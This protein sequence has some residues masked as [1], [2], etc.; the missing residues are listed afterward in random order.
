MT[1]GASGRSP[2]AGAL[3]SPGD[4]VI[5]LSPYFVEYLFYVRNAGGVPVTVET[6]DRFQPDLQAVEAALTARTRAIL[7]NTPNNPSG[8]IYPAKT[9]AALDGILTAA[10]R[11]FGSTIYAISDEPYRKIVYR[12]KQFTPPASMMRNVLVSYSHSKD[13]NLPGSGSAYSP[14]RRSPRTP[15]R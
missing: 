7:I 6:D 2:C 14:C 13:L 1:V 3:L 9:L 12:G 4:E 8:A 15:R 10:E 5:V 11:R